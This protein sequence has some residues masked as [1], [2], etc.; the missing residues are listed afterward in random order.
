[1]RGTFRTNVATLLAVQNPGL[2]TISP[3]NFDESLSVSLV[4]LLIVEV[5]DV[6]LLQWC[7]AGKSLTSTNC[8]S[9]C[10]ANF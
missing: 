10:T 4:A 2:K 5:T 8:S 1:M 3:Q 9:G 6:D 7:R